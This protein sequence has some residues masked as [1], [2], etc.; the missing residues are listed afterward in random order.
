MKTNSTSLYH[1]IRQLSPSEK[2]YFQL[3]SQRHSAGAKTEQVTLF[4]EINKNQLQSDQELNYHNNKTPLSVAKIQLFHYILDCLHQFHTVNSSLEMLKIDEHKVKI[5]SEKGLN[6]EASKLLKK[7]MQKAEEKEHFSLYLSLHQVENQII[8]KNYY[9]DSALEG[10]EERNA[11]FQ[12]CLSKLQNLEDYNHLF[13]KIY[14]F[15]FQKIKAKSKEDLQQLRLWFQDS[16]LSHESRALSKSAQII[17]FQLKALESFLE[18]NTLE[19]SRYN[20]K[21]LETIEQNELIEEGYAQK[22]LAILNNYLI[23]CLQLR[24]L[25]AF[26]QG[27]KKLKALSK[28]PVYKSLQDTEAQIFRSANQ[29]ELNYLLNQAKFAEIIELEDSIL[30]GLKKYKNKLALHSEISFHYLLMYAHF[31]R[32]NF[33]KCLDYTEILINQRNEKA[34]E[35]LIVSASLVG[36]LAHYELGNEQLL[37]YSINNLRKFQKR[38]KLLFPLEALILSAIASLIK[39]PKSERKERYRQFKEDL[40]LLQGEENEKTMLRNFDY[41]A[42]V[43]SKL[44]QLSFTEAYQKNRQDTL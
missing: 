16:L 17:F 24:K 33:E 35:S 6:K 26:E 29:L 28:I 27:L 36:I 8:S 19:A 43:D 31:A 10:L 3:F 20:L 7:T 25:E 34:A 1:L 5:L 12:S 40:L 38:R 9:Q 42:W 37:S 23:D 2:R 21:I 41:L 14:K 15:H 44:H 18:N 4:Q 22:Y 13:S 39:L 11:K 30:Q 32:N